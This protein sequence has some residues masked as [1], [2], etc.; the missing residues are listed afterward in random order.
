VDTVRALF[1]AIHAPLALRE[2]ITLPTAA[3]QKAEWQSVADLFARLDIDVRVEIDPMTYGGGWS[4]LK[5]AERE[6]AKARLTDALRTWAPQAT[7]RYRA[8]VIRDLARAYYSKA[9]R[10]GRALRTR[11]VT[12]TLR[13]AFIAYFGGDWLGFVGYLGEEVDPNEQVITAL[14]EANVLVAGAARATQAAAAL[15]IPV[16]EAAKIA[17]AYWAGSGGESPVE[18]R[19]AALGRYWRGFDEVHARQAKG[20][21]SLW[22][23]VEEGVVTVDTDPF[24]DGRIN[25]QAFLRTL[26]DGLLSEVERLWGRVMVPSHP[27]VTVSSASPHLLVAETLGPALQF[28]HGI[29]LTA[30]FICEGPYS[31]TSLEDA[32]TYYTR[33]LAALDEL[34]TPVDRTLFSDLLAAKR[35]L[36]PRPRDDEHVSSVEVAKG[37]SITLTM[38]IGPGK[39]DGF[40]HLRD[41]IT[42]HRRAW[43]ADYLERY[44]HSRWDHGTRGASVVY[45]RLLSDVGKPPSIKAFAR[46]VAP[47]VNEWFAGDISLLYAAIGERCPSPVT[48]APRILP[49]D[50]N[51]F[52]WALAAV[53]PEFPGGTSTDDAAKWERNAKAADIGRFALRWIQTWELLGHEPTLDEAGRDVFM[54]AQTIRLR[55]ENFREYRLFS[56]DPGEG[57]AAFLRLATDALRRSETTAQPE[58]SGRS[59]SGD[60]PKTSATDPTVRPATLN[61]PSAAV[62]AEPFAPPSRKGLFGR[63]GSLL[64]RSGRD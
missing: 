35:H 2:R 62:A 58:T 19:V 9:D 27:N 14:P 23:L 57:Y 8:L 11:V 22:G 20:M 6:A 46:K 3:Q 26:P 13:P 21:P 59:A 52:V 38:S 47:V 41:V 17:N 4:R 48:A 55:G 33:V 40:E 7:T 53:L 30:W 54:N 37:V 60:R 51:A 10:D 63:L 32:P 42:R 18:A 24:D 64:D 12:A 34:G 44:L 49:A 31:R 25:P 29:A 36:R 45:Q 16:A 43:A 50:P 39:Q 5:A 28:W 56:V 61:A 1:A 15:G